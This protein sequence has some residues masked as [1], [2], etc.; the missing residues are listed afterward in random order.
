MILHLLF[1]SSFA[2][3]AIKQFYAP[4]MHSEFVLVSD[5]EES[6]LDLSKYTS[7][8]IVNALSTDFHLL[9]QQLGAYKAIV[10]HGLFYPW[11][12][13]I[14]REVPSDVKVA[15]VF[16]GGDIYS[17]TDLKSGYLSPATKR[18]KALHD[19]RS[20]Y[21]YRKK[22][23]KYEIPFDILKR[24]DYC[25]TDVHEDFEFVKAYLGT[26][27][28]ELWYNYYSIEE[29]LGDLANKSIDGNN[30]L[31][32]NSSSLECNHL[33]GFRAIKRKISSKNRIIVP[34]SYGEPWLRNVILKI[35]FRFFKKSFFPLI[36]FIPRDEYNKILQGCCAIV[37]P[38]YRPQAFGNILTSMWLGSRVYLTERNHL[39]HFYNRIGLKVYSIEKDLVS[40]SFDC[41]D[42]SLIKDRE[43]N[44]R[45]L[46]SLYSKEHMHIKNKEIVNILNS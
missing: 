45:V 44:R 4:E 3:Y 2:E 16:W 29:T 15:W 5:S 26:G 6:I 19:I 12:E 7:V 1:K 17:R 41:S 39:L 9:L 30:V 33:D 43:N 38:H 11:Q 14:L 46:E 35:G 34:L 22:S 28:K 8:R 36:N 13:S 40:S 42:P 31:I 23:T 24:I 25:M 10:M 18:L 37:M 20:C 32:G 27:I 21:N